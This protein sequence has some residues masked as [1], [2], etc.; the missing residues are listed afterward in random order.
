[1]HLQRPSELRGAQE[2]Q[3]RPQLEDWLALEQRQRQQQ[4][5]KSFQ[6]APNMLRPRT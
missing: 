1:M 3:Q 6:P 4:Q 2:Q 5:P